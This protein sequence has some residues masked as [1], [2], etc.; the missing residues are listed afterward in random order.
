MDLLDDVQQLQQRYV[1]AGR[2]ES[3][4]LK[5]AA[6]LLEEIHQTKTG[7][8]PEVVTRWTFEQFLDVPDTFELW[9]GRLRP[10][11]WEMYSDLRASTSERDH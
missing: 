3:T 6:S 2:Y 10:K 5:M 9:Q 8:L 1:D 4:V 11:R 7:T